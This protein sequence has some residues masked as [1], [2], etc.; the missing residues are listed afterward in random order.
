MAE[1]Y[2]KG[3]VVSF[4]DRVA[5]ALGIQAYQIKTVAVYV[6]SVIVNYYITPAE[7]DLKTNE[8]LA[9]IQTK[10]NVLVAS[11]DTSVWGA[12]VLDATT[13]GK[14]VASSAPPG[15]PNIFDKQVVAPAPVVQ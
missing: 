8:T 13:A 12:P 9:N 15:K 11:N 3:G 2:A 14:V 5:A 10:L 7:G 1:F 6:G 4:T